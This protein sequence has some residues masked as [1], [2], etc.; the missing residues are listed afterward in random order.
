MAFD[1]GYSAL[2]FSDGTAVEIP[3]D[4]VVVLVGPNNAGKSA[5]LR[6]LTTFPTHNPGTPEPLRFVLK[7]ATVQKDGTADELMEWIDEH[8][9]SRTTLEGRTFRRAGLGFVGENVLR[10]EWAGV[11][12]Y[13]QY[14]PNV[15]N[16]VTFYAAADNRLGLLAGSGSYDPINDTPQNPMQVLFARPEVEQLISDTA[17]EAFGMPVTLSRIFGSNLDLYIGQVQAEATLVPSREYI[18]EIL[19]LPTLQSQGDGIRSFMGLMLAL[20]TA[21]FLVVIVDEP[22][23]FLHP[24]QARLLGR[25]LA[26]EAPRGT[27]VFV[28]TH[29]LDVL[30]GLLDP[31]DS[32]VTAIRL[33]RDGDVNRASVLRPEDLRDIW[34]DPLLRYSNVLEGLFHQGAVVSESDSDSRFYAAVL[35]AQRDEQALPP[36]DLLFTQSGGKQRL[37]LVVRALR[38]VSVPVAVIADFDVLREEQLLRDIVTA[39]DRDWAELR[40]LWRRVGSAINDIGTAPPVLAVKEQLNEILDA[41]PPGQLRRD[42]SQRIRAVTRVDDGWSRVKQGGLAMV[43]QGDPARLA[44]EL[45]GRLADVGLHVVPVGELERWASDIGLATARRG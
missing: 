31:V 2:E 38:A 7:S 35:D 14:C 28:A 6:E 16:F 39:L 32:V 29:N 24:P 17:Y 5:A 45:L 13:E 34:N 11:A 40:D 21:Q 44:G 8:S 27:Q 30:Q 3:V 9:F 22:E 26:T 25:K 18:E 10:G 33:V 20:V 19:R 23:A 15:S 43:P 42:D 4:G 37:P 1:F 41:A 12:P 36:H